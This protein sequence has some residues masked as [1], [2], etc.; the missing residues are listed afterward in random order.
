MNNLI[1][2]I[3]LT[4]STSI[5]NIGV[6]IT[7]GIRN[8]KIPIHSNILISIICFI[9]SLIGIY[10]GIWLANILPDIFPIIIGSIFLFFIGLRLIWLGVVHKDKNNTVNSPSLNKVINDPTDADFDNS[11]K[12]SAFEAIFLGVALSVNAL[13]NG[14]GAGLFGLPPFM[15]SLLAALGSFIS[16]W[17]GTIIGNKL[18]HVRIG[19]IELANFSTLI[20]GIIL[21]LIAA[22]LFF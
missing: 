14:I 21:L 6:G 18:A 5:D 17:L 1:F 19:N 7:Y 8:I 16:I 3:A 22:S 2:I 4:I 10:S 13:T 9:L 20:S 11:Q 12:I 15:I